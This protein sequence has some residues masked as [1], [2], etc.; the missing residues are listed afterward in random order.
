MPSAHGK[1]FAMDLRVPLRAAE[2]DHEHDPPAE[3]RKVPPLLPEEGSEDREARGPTKSVAVLP[4]DDL[5][6][7]GV[8]SRRSRI[9]LFAGHVVQHRREPIQ[10]PDNK[11]STLALDDADPR[12]AIELACDP[13][14]W[15]LTRLAISAWVGAGLRRALLPCFGARLANRSNSACMRLLTARVLNS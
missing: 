5:S 15:V 12:Q 9:V 2:E 6:A 3:V 7:A 1:L 10:I 13:S 4:F 14:R 8:L 11:R